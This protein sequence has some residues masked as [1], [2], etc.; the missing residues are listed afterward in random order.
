M[1][2]KKCLYNYS[3]ENNLPYFTHMKKLH[4]TFE[5]QKHYKHISSGICHHMMYEKRFW[6]EVI[7]LVEKT[8]NKEFWKVFIEKVNKKD[9][10]GA[11]GYEIYFHYIVNNHNDKIKIRKLN[12]I[13]SSDFEKDKNSNYDYISWH[14]Y[15]R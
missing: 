1:E 6:K 12:W 7:D 5:R 3:N 2:G 4:N 13:N 14:W 10:S 9:K 8:N 15:K 11:A